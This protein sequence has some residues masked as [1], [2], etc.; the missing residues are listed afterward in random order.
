MCLPPARG[1]RGGRRAGPRAVSV[2]LCCSLHA[3]LLSQTAV[4]T[5]CVRAALPGGLYTPQAHRSHTRRF[6]VILL[7]HPQT[8]GLHPGRLPRSACPLLRGLHASLD[9]PR[10]SLPTPALPPPSHILSRLRVPASSE[11]FGGQTGG[12]E[13]E[14]DSE[15]RRGLPPSCP[16]SPGSVRSPGAALCP[17]TTGP[18]PQH[19]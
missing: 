15:E 18:L 16:S 11:H 8:F 5:V 1:C 4:G 2:H 13:A 9:F 7:P 17:G 12:Q 14:Q 19:G 6:L 10:G 3:P